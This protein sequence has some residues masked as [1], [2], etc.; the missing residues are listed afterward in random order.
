[1]LSNADKGSYL[2]LMAYIRE[3]PETDK[4]FSNY[5]KHLAE[6]CSIPTTLGYGPR[7]LHSTGQLHKGGPGNGLFIQ[8][9][10][11]HRQDLPIPGKPYTFGILADAEAKGDMEALQAAGRRAI[12]IH[13]NV[14]EENIA[15]ELS[16]RLT[17]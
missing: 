3:T 2:A 15:K 8:I 12:S 9:T 10:S 16:D 13:L 7:F 11:A 4:I 17:Y 14:P 5:R 1:L 6:R